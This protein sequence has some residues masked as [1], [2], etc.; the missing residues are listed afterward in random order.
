MAE[1][2]TY[3]VRCRGGKC[4]FRVKKKD[5]VSLQLFDRVVWACVPAHASN[6]TAAETRQR[7]KEND[8][9]MEKS[10]KCHW[11]ACTTCTSQNETKGF[12]LLGRRSRN[13]RDPKGERR[14]CLRKLAVQRQRSG[15]G[16]AETHRLL[17]GSS[18]EK[19]EEEERIMM[20]RRIREAEKAET[21]SRLPSNSPLNVSV[22]SGP[23][24]ALGHKATS[25]GR[26]SV[27]K[28]PT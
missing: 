27:S 16:K 28:T 13:Q 19:S 8:G 1:V 4:F 22:P 3:T 15:N 14:V 25:L 20:G 10:T 26:H 2:E 18:A 17:Q 24:F 5:A 9:S 11:L 23:R 21:S 12:K 6:S 7:N